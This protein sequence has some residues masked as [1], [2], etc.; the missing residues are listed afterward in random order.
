MGRNGASCSAGKWDVGLIKV[1][2]FQGSSF[3]Y[4]WLI[5]YKDNDYLPPCSVASVLSTVVCLNDRF[6]CAVKEHKDRVEK[7]YIF[8]LHADFF[9]QVQL[10][11][12]KMTLVC[13]TP[14]LFFRTI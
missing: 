14:R 11:S 2:N 12:V 5:K 1:C 10:N 3:E 6:E 7:E 13:A 4:A 9:K 8:K